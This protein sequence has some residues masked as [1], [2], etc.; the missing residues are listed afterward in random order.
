VVSSSV[1]VSLSFVLL[2][3]L[4]HVRPGMI[5]I[6]IAVVD[7]DGEVE[8]LVRSRRRDAG[9]GEVVDDD[10]V[11]TKRVPNRPEEPTSLGVGRAGPS[12]GVPDRSSVSSPIGDELSSE[13]GFDSLCNNTRW[14]E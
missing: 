8:V 3:A 14:K 4:I 2:L 7:T 12:K 9:G 11:L 13:D 10:L 6:V 5:A 1:L